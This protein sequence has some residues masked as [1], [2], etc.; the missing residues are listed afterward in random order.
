MKMLVM[1]DVDDN[2]EEDDD[3]ENDNEKGQQMTTAVIMMITEELCT[4]ILHITHKGV[5]VCSRYSLALNTFAG[6][7][8][9]G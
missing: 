7:I 6:D 2:D 9:I 5:Q 3:N 4:F 1:N 8:L